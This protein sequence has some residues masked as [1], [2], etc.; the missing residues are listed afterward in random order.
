MVHFLFLFLAVVLAAGVYAWEARAPK[1][2]W[3]L[4]RKVSNGRAGLYKRRKHVKFGK[5][6]RSFST[7][8]V[9]HTPTPGKVWHFVWRIDRIQKG[10]RTIGL[11][12]SINTAG[13][14]HLHEVGFSPPLGLYM[15]YTGEEDNL[16][17]PEREQY[18]LDLYRQTSAQHK[19]WREDPAFSI[20]RTLSRWKLSALAFVVLAGTGLW[21]LPYGVEAPQVIVG[22]LIGMMGVGLLATIPCVIKS[23]HSAMWA[24]ACGMALLLS[25]LV[26]V[27]SIP[28]ALLGVNGLSFSTLCEGSVPV[29]RSWTTGVGVEQMYYVDVSLPKTCE[30]DARKVAIG[31]ELYYEFQMGRRVVDVVVEQGHLGYKRI[32]LIGS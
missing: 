24:K 6:E 9:L 11:S 27:V 13:K 16:N 1:E 20:L 18:L 23:Q 22:A 8:A 29:E 2:K 19:K 14:K 4:L 25:C 32:K 17:Y 26:S 15:V 31:S 7:Y 5:F 12:D 21:I 10:G 3:E 28:S 30:F